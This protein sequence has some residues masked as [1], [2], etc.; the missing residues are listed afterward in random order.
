MRSRLKTEVE[1]FYLPFKPKRRTRASIARERGLEPLADMIW[2]Q[3]GDEIPADAAAAFVST[4]KGVA[5]ADAAL[6]GARD[7][8]AERVA[9]TAEIRKLLRDAF[10]EHG[11]IAAKKPKSTERDDQV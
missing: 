11:L 4:E 1:D 7:I 2:S 10:V 5:D 8:C 3:K 6:A 9:D